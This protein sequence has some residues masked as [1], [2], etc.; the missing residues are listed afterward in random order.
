MRVPRPADEWAHFNTH[1]SSVS[2]HEIDTSR[3][4]IGQAE[5]GQ[6]SPLLISKQNQ[7]V[8]F[9]GRTRSCVSNGRTC[10]YSLPALAVQWERL[11]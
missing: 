7:V 6:P 1:L 2:R 10:I 8:I 9:D 4:G 3:Q 5:I 11:D